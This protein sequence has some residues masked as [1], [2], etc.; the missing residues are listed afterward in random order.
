MEKK[1]Q[2]LEKQ[3]G[4]RALLLLSENYQRDMLNNYGDFFEARSP[5]TFR[6]RDGVSMIDLEDNFRWV[7]PVRLYEAVTSSAALRELGVCA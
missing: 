2:K 4:E 3:P 1:S 5:N 7:M 6:L